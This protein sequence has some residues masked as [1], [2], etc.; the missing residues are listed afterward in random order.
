MII[1]EKK[2]KWEEQFL[3]TDKEIFR[4]ENKEEIEEAEVGDS[5]FLENRAHN[6]QKYASFEPRIIRR[7]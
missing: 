7:S 3:E 2:N 5:P 6:K 4:Q 1:A